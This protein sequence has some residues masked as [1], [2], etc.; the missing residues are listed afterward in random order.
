LSRLAIGAWL[1][2]RR[3]RAPEWP[4]LA[5]RSEYGGNPSAQIEILEIC[6]AAKLYRRTATLTQVGVIVTTGDLK[7]AKNRKGTLG[8]TAIDAQC[9]APDGQVRFQAGPFYYSDVMD[10]PQPLA[11][12]SGSYGHLRPPEKYPEE[13]QVMP[14][15]GK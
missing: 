5:L 4:A 7:Y 12:W 2:G 3:V 9:P 11:D 6:P 8:W 15:A 14:K 13:W 1:K 10:D